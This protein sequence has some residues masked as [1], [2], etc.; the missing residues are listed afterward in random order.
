[1]Y[2]IVIWVNR[3]SP[4]EKWLIN[5]KD[6]L[7]IGEDNRYLSWNELQLTSDQLERVDSNT[8]FIFD[9]HGENE[10]YKT[11]CYYYLKSPQNK[12]KE[13]SSNQIITS[14][15]NNLKDAGLEYGASLHIMSCFA[16]KGHDKILKEV[17]KH[18][19]LGEWAY[20]TI[21]KL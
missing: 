12:I 3:E 11:E 5:N 6:I 13:Y 7:I 20:N 8:Q 16:G 10:K 4:V 21:C 18:N 1:M 15:F 14:I 2:K 19:V 9:S 17:N